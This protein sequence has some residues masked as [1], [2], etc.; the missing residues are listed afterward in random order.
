MKGFPKTLS[1]K[2]DYEYVK[3]NFPEE[4][5]KPAWQRLLD[6]RKNW[7]PIGEVESMEAG[8]TDELHKVEESSDY[9]G[10]TIYTQYK[11]QT[12]PN[13][14]LKRLGFTVKEVEQALA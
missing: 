2:A 7:F 9:E 14:T 3:E 1:T 10:N 12:D 8:M 5:W 11:L 6:E 13:C 4:Q